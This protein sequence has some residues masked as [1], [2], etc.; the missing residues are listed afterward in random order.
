[1]NNN[2]FSLLFS[3]PLLIIYKTHSQ[4]YKE[5]DVNALCMNKHMGYVKV[6]QFNPPNP[7]TPNH[8]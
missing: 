1:M 4:K 7:L 5:L 8:K 3:Q 6:H 2:I